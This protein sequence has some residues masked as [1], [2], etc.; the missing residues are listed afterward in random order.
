MRTITGLF[1]THEQAAEAV[2]ALRDAGVRSEDISLV[3]N[4]AEGHAINDDDDVAEGAGAG[5]GIG[6]ILGGA[7]GLLA[8]L[9]V[10]AIPGVG[11]VIAGGWLLSTAVGA[12]AGAVVGGATGG[13][14]GALTEAGISEAEAHTYAEGV[15]RGGTLVTARV[16][17][18]KADA[19]D[20]ILHKGGRID[21][22]T[23]R[24]DYEAEGWERFDEDAPAYTPDEVNA[25]RSS[26]IPPVL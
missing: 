14:I 21:I 16:E 25:Y 17:D 8:G 9:G 23:R 10:L 5:A 1:D 22:A 18:S 4:N 7:G 6:A 13:L 2:R 26:Y 15:R 3:A 11:P 12:V 19:A 20:L 24:K